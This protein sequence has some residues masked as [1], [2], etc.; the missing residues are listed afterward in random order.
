[1]HRWIVGILV[2]LALLGGA[3]AYFTGVLPF[4]PSR[5]RFES[6][7]T[8]GSHSRVF[9]VPLEPEPAGGRRPAQ[10]VWKSLVDELR[11][12]EPA[13]QLLTRLHGDLPSVII[14]AEPPQDFVPEGIGA[15]TVPDTYRFSATW[16]DPIGP[17]LERWSDIVA[18]IGGRSDAPV[19]CLLGTWKTHRVTRFRIESN[20][21]RGD[22]ALSN[23]LSMK[24]DEPAAILFAAND[25]LLR[26]QAGWI[27]LD[28]AE[29]H[30]YVAKPTKLDAATARRE[31]DEKIDAYCRERYE[32][33][34]Q[35]PAAST[36]TPRPVPDFT[37]H[38]SNDILRSTNDAPAGTR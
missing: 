24:C 8:Q 22:L 13:R 10:E 15:T 4:G 11:Q 19:E 1:M 7:S 35:Q 28:E 29:G 17:G 21:T 14:T 31:L 5:D 34:T 27:L 6:T 25:Y 3:T 33:P 36:A 12:E 2:A 32:K 23:M 37:P 38:T 20:K 18:E 30:R 16:F 26:K 9:L